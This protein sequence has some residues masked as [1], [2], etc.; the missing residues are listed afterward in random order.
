[1]ILKRTYNLETLDSTDPSN[2]SPRAKIP[3]HIP[4]GV[5][6]PRPLWFPKQNNNC[7]HHT[8]YPSNLFPF[9]LFCSL[10]LFIPV[11]NTRVLPVEYDPLGVHIP[12]TVLPRSSLLSPEE[13][14]LHTKGPRV[15][16]GHFPLVNPC[17]E[18]RQKRPLLCTTL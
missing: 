4:R 10:P 1:M 9:L 12:V 11:L 16:V 7:C 5:P 15:D 13:T 8:S 18:R 17:E 2:H 14:R 6:D 3:F